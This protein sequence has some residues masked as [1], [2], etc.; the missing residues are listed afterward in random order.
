MD[1]GTLT[2]GLSRSHCTRVA[3]VISTMTCLKIGTG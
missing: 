3:G 2:L 1:D